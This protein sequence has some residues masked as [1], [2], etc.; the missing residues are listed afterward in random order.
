MKK[1]M[2]IALL[3]VSFAAGTSFAADWPATP[4]QQPYRPGPLLPVE[5]TGLYFGVNA[6]YGWATGSST[7][8]FMG[9]FPGGSAT[10]FA[11]GATELAG[12]SLAGSSSLRG[13]IAGG[14]IG[15][16]WKTG[17]VVFGAELDAQWSGQQN[18][19]LAV[20]TGA[21]TATEAVRIKSLTTGRARIGWPLTG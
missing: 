16:N 13:G 2:V 6:G 15:F 11:L 18:T 14:Q 9:Q 10:P 7:T 3:A 12:T 8:V 19:A 5:W 21:C 20:C 4:L 1:R 17:M